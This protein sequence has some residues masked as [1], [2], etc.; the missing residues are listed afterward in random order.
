MRRLAALALLSIALAGCQLLPS[1][2]GARPTPTP[3]GPPNVRGHVQAGPVCPVEREPPDPRCAPRPVA[4][5]LQISDAH[6]SNAASVVSDATGNFSVALPPGDYTLTAQ[7]V[8]GL[9]GTPAPIT[10]TVTA[11]SPVDLT[12]EYDTGIR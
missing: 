10:F 12:V 6:G 9:M 2:G 8:S 4:A 5:M 1:L 11:G 7:P 3:S